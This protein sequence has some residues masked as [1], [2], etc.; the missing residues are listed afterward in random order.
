MRVD[1]RRGR[2]VLPE[3]FRDAE[4][5]LV[6]DD[7]ESDALLYWL[8]GF[9][10]EET[11]AALMVSRFVARLHTIELVASHTHRVLVVAIVVVTAHAHWPRVGS[12]AIHAQ[13]LATRHE[14]IST[15]DG[16]VMGRHY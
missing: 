1:E 14:A 3:L 5:L 11:S 9:L 4:R 7:A 2:V 8:A 15:V 13:G 6:G 10:D 16:I 12:R